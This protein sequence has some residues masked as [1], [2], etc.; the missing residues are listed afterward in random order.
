MESRSGTSRP[1]DPA[2][3]T[4]W[5]VFAIAAAFALLQLATEWI[6]PWGLLHDELYYWAGAQRL[7]L[8]YVDH[9][10]LTPWVLAVATTLLGDGR[11]PFA[12]VPALCH[13]ATVLFAG[14]MARDLGARS[15]GQVLAALGVGLAPFNLIIF[16]FYSANALEV[17]FW[18]AFTF[19]FVRLI[20]TGNERLWLGLGV[21]AGLGLLN[22]HTF[23][24]LGGAIALGTLAT[25]LRAQLRS[26]WL[27][28]GLAIALLLASP[29]LLWNAYYDWPSLEFY[30]SRP[31]V[32]L[33]TTLAEA[34][35]L[36]VLGAGPANLLIWVPG[37]LF[38]LLSRRARPFRPAAITFAVVFIVIL[39]AGQRRG[40][41]IAG[42]YPV[43]MAAGATF[44]DQWSGRGHRAVR[45]ALI[46]AILLVG[47]LLIPVTL[48]ILS[49]E[50]TGRY[51]EAID[52][53]PEIEVHD[54]GQPIP[55]YLSGRLEWDR[56]ADAVA[57][58][59]EALPPEQQARTV[60]L[61]PH[62][63]TASVVQYHGRD[64]GFPP[65][66]SPHNAYWF[67]RE[68]A[69]GRDVVLAVAIEPERLSA[70]FAAVREVGMFRCQYC[71]SFRPNRPIVLATGP[72]RPLEDLL[73]EWRFFSINPSPQLAP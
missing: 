72:V 29:N 40:D 3:P 16:S 30:Q 38:L 70:Y 43:L 34:F 31:N 56:L 28:A 37:L 51:F 71:T 5:L 41:R 17:V 50:A 67:W 65:V 23:V 11:L 19:L 35:E 21:V 26:R 55:I 25:P 1:G 68:D 64:R 22:K 59:W 58:A 52:E 57:E 4:S 36:Q 63:L 10:P 69:A 24:M 39:V 13:G 12:L 9:P 46:A 14:W 61:A 32:D 49:P 27:W 33:P 6:E 53:K 62:W 44:W 20:R 48:P 60:V 66:V 73:T 42:I 15:F 2:S 18:A 8:G 7:G 54:V 47:G 45:V